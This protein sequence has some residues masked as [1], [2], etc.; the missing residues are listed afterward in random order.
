MTANHTSVIVT[1]SNWLKH[2]NN[3]TL[4][5]AWQCLFSIVTW[6]CAPTPCTV[7]YTS[8]HLGLDFCLLCSLLKVHWRFGGTCL[9]YLQ[10]R[11]ISKARNQQSFLP[12]L[13][14]FL[15]WFILR[16]WRWK[17]YPPRN[18]GNF[19]Q[20]TRRY[21]PEDNL[22]RT[23]PVKTWNATYIL[24]II[25]YITSLIA[26]CEE[27]SIDPLSALFQFIS[28]F[29]QVINQTLKKEVKLSL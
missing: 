13:C 14:S 18:V 1:L 11:R 15:A 25:R 4:V 21:I 7:P 24:H 3:W 6:R 27:R 23:T 28:D 2:R 5:C 26:V 29:A 10:G 12:A 8:N 19:Q 16:T 22:I 17:R 9:L 20:T